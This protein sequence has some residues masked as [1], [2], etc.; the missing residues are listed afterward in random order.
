MTEQDYSKVKEPKFQCFV[1]TAKLHFI[2]WI[3]WIFLKLFVAGHQCHNSIFF[4]LF[5][6]FPEFPPLLRTPLCFPTPTVFLLLTHPQRFCSDLCPMFFSTTIN[7]SSI[8]TIS[9][10]GTISTTGVLLP[11]PHLPTS[12]FSNT[13]RR[14][15]LLSPLVEHHDG[16]KEIRMNGKIID[17]P[18][19]VR[20][21]N[22]FST[23]FIFKLGKVVLY[24]NCRLFC[25]FSRS[26]QFLIHYLSTFL[27]LSHILYLSVVLPPT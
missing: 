20:M 9:T 19:V 15:R 16:S 21:Q 14:P 8:V 1:I 27:S 22:L 24:S 12:R 2:K 17:L 26:I 23:G 18:Y 25:S 11:L 7:T 6:G 10:S 3:F 4:S 13:S 5:P